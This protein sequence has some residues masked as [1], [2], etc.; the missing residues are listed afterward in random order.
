M[1][2]DE[3]RPNLNYDL[4]T[5]LDF[6]AQV[7][8][9]GAAYSFTGSLNLNTEVQFNALVWSDVRS[10]PAWSDLDPTSDA[11][12]LWKIFFK[13]QS[14]SFE[15]LINALSSYVAPYNHSHAQSDVTNLVTDLGAKASSSAMTTALGLKADASAVST[16]LSGKAPTSHSHTQSDVTN[17]TTDLSGKAA[18]SHAHAQSDITNLLTDLAKKLGTSTDNLLIKELSGSLS[19]GEVTFSLSGFSSIVF[20]DATLHDAGDNIT[21]AFAVEKT[22]STSSVTFKFTSGANMLLLGNSTRAAPGTG[23]VKA[24]VIGVKA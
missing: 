9:N 2:W 12:N 6:H 23:T 20:T 8:L 10:K 5:V 19:G 18:S 21:A 16:A 24:I 14:V 17:L 7:I 1:I 22:I 13:S 3:F 4:A 15:I 11:F